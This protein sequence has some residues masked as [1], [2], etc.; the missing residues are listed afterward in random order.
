METHTHNWLERT[1]LL[2]GSEKLELLRNAHVLVVGLGGVG[3]Y[4]AE[5]IA[6]AGVACLVPALGFPA[7]CFAS[8]AAWLMA[9]VFLVP[10]YF[11]CCRRLSAPERVK[12]PKQKAVHA[13]S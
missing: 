12:A 13:A 11:W 6:R 2:L 10:A 3:A 9:D 7:A 4:A 8:P 5:M 1:E